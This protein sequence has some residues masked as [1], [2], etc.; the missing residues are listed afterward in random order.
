VDALPGPAIAATIEHVGDAVDPETRSLPVRCSVANPG[1]A[2]KAGMFA[3]LRIGAAQGAMEGDEALTAPSAAILRGGE[4]P[5]VWCLDGARAYVRKPIAI[6]DE[7]DGVA[8]IAS[9]LDGDERV[10]VEGGIFL[11][12]RA[13]R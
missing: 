12:S 5:A 3:E 7:R 8:S 2:L 4:T 6:G 10:V 13:D 1:G 9:G 11:D